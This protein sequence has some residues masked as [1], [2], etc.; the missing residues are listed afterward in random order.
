MSGMRAARAAAPA[1][2][3]ER[4]LLVCGAPD[5]ALVVASSQREIAMAI[6]STPAD[7]AHHLE[8]FHPTCV[9]LDMDQIEGI[10]AP[11]ALFSSGA[12]PMRRVLLASPAAFFLGLE[13]VAERR[14]DHVLMKPACAE[15][16]LATIGSSAAAPRLPS[17]DRIQWEYIQAVL[18]SCQGNVS[19]AA[20]QLGMFRQSLQRILRRHPPRQ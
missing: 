7:L 10:D 6:A 8:H 14:A 19:E 15:D 20:R 2:R 3:A 18:G 4:V 11:R 9:L 17:L 16:V 13:W 12:R 1:E 5:P